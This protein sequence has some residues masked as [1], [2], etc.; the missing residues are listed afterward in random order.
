MCIRVKIGEEKGKDRKAELWG[1]YVLNIFFSSIS[2]TP[3]I[4]FV[5]VIF[6]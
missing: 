2:V 6:I 5:G 3:Y 4:V 1:N